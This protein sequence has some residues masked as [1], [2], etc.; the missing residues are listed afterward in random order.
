MSSRSSAGG[1]GAGGGTEFQARVAAWL[2]VQI[3]AERGAAQAFGL[4]SALTLERLRCETGEG[5]DDLLVET[6]DQGFAFIQA[7]RRLDLSGLAESPLA[8]TL[9]QFVRQFV[10]ERLPAPALGAPWH[11][12]LEAGGDRLVLTVGSRTPS[13]IRADL[14]AVARRA[15]GLAPG[16]P[17]AAAAVSDRERRALRVVMTHLQAS[18]RSVLGVDATEEEMRRLLS[19]AHVQVLEVEAD[20]SEE[21][22]A[23]YLLRQVVL[24]EPAQADAAWACLFKH[25]SGMITSRT[26]TDRVAL[27]RLLISHGIEPQAAPSYRADVGRL[28][29]HSSR[30]LSVL[31]DLSVMRVGGVEVKLERRCVAELRRAGEEGSLLVIGEPGAGK[32]GA[33]HDLVASLGEARDVVVLVVDRHEAPTL[34]ALNRELGLEHDLVEVLASWPGPEPA[35]LV[36]DALDAARAEPA[37]RTLRD[38]FRGVS[39]QAA[40]WRVVSS[41]RKFDLRH[42]PELRE[43]FAGGAPCGLADPEFAATRHVEVR[44]LTAEELTQI[45]SQSPELQALVEAATPELRQLISVAFNL[46]LAAE[47]LGQGVA[48]AALTP[49][50]TQ[51]ELLDRYWQYRVI[52]HDGQGDAREAVS[53]RACARMIEVRRLRVA[54]SEIVDV[55]SSAALHELLRAHVLTAWRPSAADA[56]D[57]YVLHHFLFDYAV[58]RLILREEPAALVDRIAADPEL[59]LMVRPSLALH[60]EYLWAVAPASH[61][62]FWD[63]VLRMAR[64]ERVP[65]IGKLIGP[66]V[67]ARHA[68]RLAELEPLLRL[69]E[70]VSE[71]DLS[72]PERALRHIVGALVSGP[73]EGSPLVGPEAGPWCELLERLS[74]TGGGALSYT[75]RPLLH[76]VCKSPAAMSP[77]QMSS[78]GRA[79]RCLLEFAWRQAPRD[80]R[81]VLS[82]IELVPVLEF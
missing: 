76:E 54:R 63:L 1:A 29:V 37:A 44:H 3:L 82:G 72:P 46:H 78:A 19:L 22:A 47:L 75:V 38:V 34:H 64:E 69:V 27:Q 42:S 80:T 6:S 23:K 30:M 14:S 32:S 51:L 65:E 39:R 66:A 7:K 15:A 12:A 8:S 40:R 59:V 45:G 25:C 53:R 71:C 31:R 55:A 62:R 33:L 9:N 79:A 18:W 48:V 26:G 58:A 11:R 52:R 24:R 57:S 21:R 81:L 67:A 16:Q 2:A 61:E 50:R 4:G 43:M 5:V 77:N 13:T 41:I 17:L 20:E 56:A 36:V 68:A 49:L 73:T 60:Y 70:S 74:R 35:W 28:R 10:A